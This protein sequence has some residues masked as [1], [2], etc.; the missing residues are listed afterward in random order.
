MRLDAHAH[1]TFS[2]PVSDRYVRWSLKESYSS[3]QDVYRRA[4]AN[5]MDLVAV[6]DHDTI[7]GALEIAHHDDVIIGCEVTAFFADE[8]F[9]VHLGVL[10]ITED[11]HREI[12]R[13]R[14]NVRELMPYL[15][16]QGIFTTLNH[17]ASSVT[18]P[19]TANHILSLMPWMDGIETLNGALLPSQNRTATALAEAYG[20]SRVGGSDSHTLSRIGRTYLEAEATDRASFMD[21]V[22]NGKAR[23]GGDHCSCFTLWSDIVRIS[24]CFFRD[25]ITR[26]LRDPSDTRNQKLALMV[27]PG[28]PLMALAL[29]G[30][31]V[32]LMMEER[33]NHSLLFD[34]VAKQRSSAFELAGN[35]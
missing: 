19:I 12:Q 14:H 22:R 18:G 17:V 2:K 10:D 27:L 31:P 35:Q 21:A 6:T 8:G 20:K 34:L 11:Q 26:F 25:G 7:D 33:F 13:L 4:K 23:V 30:A 24:A 28:I 15:K 32:Y 29:V 3:P 1:T 5:E 9:P 16:Y